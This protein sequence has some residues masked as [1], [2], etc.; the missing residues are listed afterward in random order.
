DASAPRAASSWRMGMEKKSWKDQLAAVEQ[1]LQD[2][3]AEVQRTIRGLAER[4]A[5]SRRE[6]EELV[7]KV[8]G[9]ELVAHAA[10]LRDR[11]G[12]TGVEVLERFEG[13]QQQ[14]CERIGIAT[15]RQ[16]AELGERVN[17]LSRRLEKLS[18]QAR[19][20]NARDGSGAAKAARKPA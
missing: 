3:E 10:E 8:K 13:A 18:R 1:R 19:V 17:R 5:A 15:R 16:L 4:G 7:A 14:A 11:A 6:L 20:A 2:Y 12:K 9:G